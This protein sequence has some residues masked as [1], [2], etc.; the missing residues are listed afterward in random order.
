[1][2][3]YALLRTQQKRRLHKIGVDLVA[4]GVYALVFVLS[5]YVH[6]T[7]KIRY[8]NSIMFAY[9][10]D[11]SQNINLICEKKALQLRFLLT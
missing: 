5:L 8:V 9:V 3:N 2:D 1:M 4:R 11:F 10:I 7:P 6:Y